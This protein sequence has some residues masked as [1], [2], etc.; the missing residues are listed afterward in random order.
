MA[1]HKAVLLAAG[2]GEARFKP[3]ALSLSLGRALAR[4]LKELC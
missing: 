1:E 4:I 2:L 3:R